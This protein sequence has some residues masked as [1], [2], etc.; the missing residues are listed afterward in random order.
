MTVVL[1][2]GAWEAEVR[3]EVG[4]SLATLRRDGVDVLRP[5][6]TDSTDPL[7]AACFPLAPWCNRVRDSRFTHG[8]RAIILP[9]NFPP[10]PHSLHGLSW[11]RPWT[12]ERRTDA[13]C[14]LADEYDGAGSWPWAFRA[15]QQ[16][17]LEA[18]GLTLTLALANPSDEPMPAGLGLH[19]YFRRRPETRVRFA[20]GH[21]LLAQPD[22]LPTGEIAPADR[23][24]DWA[25]GAPLPGETVD[26]CFAEWSG[27]AEIAD[28]LGTI[29]LT[30]HGAPFLHLYAPADVSALCLEPVSHSPDALNRAPEE[31]L[32][33]APG[34]STGLTMRIAAGP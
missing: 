22:C 9:A 27:D 17:A 31:M 24:G 8:T 12:V 23:F 25:A 14:R 32:V 15:E 26:H 30:A 3:P 34:Q 16:I 18:D 1:R 29:A 21:V 11:H 4:G 10:E 5:M 33:L 2:A 20:A 19:P 6:P 13:E 28:S 7:H